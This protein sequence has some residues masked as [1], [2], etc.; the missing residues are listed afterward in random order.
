MRAPKLLVAISSVLALGSGVLLSA[1]PASAYVA[2]NSNG[3]CWRTGSKMH[4]SGV[5]LSYHDDDWWDVH[6]ADPQ[7][8]WHDED[9]DHRW[10]HGYWK[11]GTWVGGF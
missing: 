1:T 6:K 8:H 5:V 10:E 2:C 3:D 11:S 4:W 7:Y 9:T